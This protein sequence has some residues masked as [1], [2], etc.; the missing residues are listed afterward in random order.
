MEISGI[1][2]MR[3]N[4]KYYDKKG[5]GMEEQITFLSQEIVAVN[6]S[7]SVDEMMLIEARARQ[8]YYMAFNE[9]LKNSPEFKFVKRTKRP[10]MDEI[11]AMISFGNT[12][13]YNQFLQMITKTA[14][15]PRI[16]MVHATNRRNYSLNLDFA[17]I[18]KP[19]VSDRVIF[20]LINFKQ[21]KTEKHFQKNEDGSVYMNKQGKRIFLEK[22]EEKLN[23]KIVIKNK[24][25]TY[26]Q[27]MIEEV[28]NFQKFILDGEKYNPY[29]YY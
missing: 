12:L 11:N 26:K 10:P 23:S 15:D 9:I 3:A 18:F 14:L 17:D 27:L 25:Q 24:S 2:N 29:K 8:T 16:G 13:L 7:N 5:C 22:F 21:I 28:R 6:E 19:I 20:A 4:L 1:H